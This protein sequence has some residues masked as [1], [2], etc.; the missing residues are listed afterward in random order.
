M[1]RPNGLLLGALDLVH[2]GLDILGVKSVHELHSP[3]HQ[4]GVFLRGL[5][6]GDV[7]LGLTTD[8]SYMNEEQFY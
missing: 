5:R 3:G 7:D 4:L 8:S 2:L 1:R 6:L